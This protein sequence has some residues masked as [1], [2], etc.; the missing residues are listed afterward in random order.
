MYLLLLLLKKQFL[1]E[2]SVVVIEQM[3]EFADCCDWGIDDLG[4][5]LVLATSLHALESS[6]DGDNLAHVGSE[7][8]QSCVVSPVLLVSAHMGLKLWLCY[9]Q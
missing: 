5:G 1:G 3:H 4:H 9:R 8:I 2:I 7:E 6:L